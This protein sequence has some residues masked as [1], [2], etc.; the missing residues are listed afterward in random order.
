METRALLFYSETMNWIKREEASHR[1][2]SDCRIDTTCDGRHDFIRTPFWSFKY[3]LES[4][5]NI[6]SKG[7]ESSPYLFEVKRNRRFTTE[8]FSATVLRHPIFVQWAVY[9]VESNSDVS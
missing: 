6:L 1:L 8:S 9:Q 3:F 7:P 4:L 2:D 5:S